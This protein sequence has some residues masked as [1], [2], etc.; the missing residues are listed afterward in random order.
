VSDP[1]DRSS[2]RKRGSSEGPVAEVKALSHTAIRVR[3]I[4]ASVKF[5]Q[6]LFGYDVFIDGRGQQPVGPVLGLIGGHTV[7]LLL[8]PAEAGA[9]AP[10]DVLGHSCIAFSVDDIDATHAAV[11]AAGYIRSDKPETFG[12]VRVVF[13]RDPDGTLLEFIELPGKRGSMAQVA[14]RMREKAGA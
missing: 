7:E 13:V 14:A 1:L 2:P 6:D 5:Y 8:Q 9:K 11:K 4:D 12:N 3:D 10:R